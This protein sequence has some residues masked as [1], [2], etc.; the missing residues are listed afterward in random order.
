MNVEINSEQDL[1]K[2]TSCNSLSM[3]PFGVSKEDPTDPPLKRHVFILFS[4]GEN[5]V[6][7]YWQ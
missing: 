6:V 3:C 4:I 7:M 5:R 1:P 2:K